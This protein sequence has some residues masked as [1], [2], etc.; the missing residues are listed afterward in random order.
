MAPSFVS[1]VV[2]I[3]AAIF[4]DVGIDA[5]NTT[6]NTLVI[7]V[8]GLVLMVRQVMTNRSNWFGARPTGFTA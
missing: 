1:A 6:F 4:P 5:L 8:G 3:L 7:I 2:M